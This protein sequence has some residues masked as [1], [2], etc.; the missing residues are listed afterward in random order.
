MSYV[1]SIF[2]AS[3]HATYI[4]TQEIIV[5]PTNNFTVYYYHTVIKHHD[6]NNN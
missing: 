5:Q 4:F 1:R 3:M 2:K 6:N